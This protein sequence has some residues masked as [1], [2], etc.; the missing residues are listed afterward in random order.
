VY[1]VLELR[2]KMDAAHVQTAQDTR[3]YDEVRKTFP[4]MPTTTENL[5]AT[6][7]RFGEIERVAANP[8]SML[9]EISNVLGAFSAIE[10][11]RIDWAVARSSAEVGPADTVNA[12]APRA[13]AAPPVPAAQDKTRYQVA[14]VSG[15]VLIPNRLDYRGMLDYL[16]QFAEA[17]RKFPDTRVDL[18][19]LPFDTRSAAKL[20]GG[21]STE[22]APQATTFALRM[23]RKI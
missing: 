10:L 6:V 15:R 12:A 18:V 13:P 9:V 8:E 5:K 20:S 1:E 7:Q 23:S 11:D 21:V 14:Y 17:L 4:P 2:S 16:N 19:K 3:R 22:Q